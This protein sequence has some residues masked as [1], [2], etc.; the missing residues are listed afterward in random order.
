VNGGHRSDRTL[1]RTWSLC[2]W[3]RPVSAQ[4]VSVSRLSDRTRWRVRSRSTGRV[5]SL[6]ELTGLQPDAGTMVSGSSSVRVRS[7]LRWS[8]ARLDQRVWSV[9]GPAR[10]I[11]CRAS[12]QFNQCVQSCFVHGWCTHLRVQSVLTSVSGQRDCIVFL[13]LTAL[14]KGVHL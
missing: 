13:C 8:I 7:L 11:E 6:W 9:T 1:V 5:R 3:T 10:S 12:G 4:R 14:F 2:D